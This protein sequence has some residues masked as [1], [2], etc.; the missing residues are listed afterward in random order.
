MDLEEKQADIKD[1]CETIREVNYLDP[2]YN[3]DSK[4]SYDV[5]RERSSEKKDIAGVFYE[6]QNLR[7]LTFTRA[8]I[9]FPEA[10]DFA[11][12]CKEN[13]VDI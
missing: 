4:L 2:L 13:K 5:W 3:T 10:A 1:V 11:K 7:A 12:F 8:A 6:P 9:D